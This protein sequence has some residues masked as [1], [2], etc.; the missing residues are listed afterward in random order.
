VNR[1]F[2]RVVVEEARTEDPIVLVQDYHF[3]LAPSSFGSAC[4]GPP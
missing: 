2:A 3:V 4:P 1:R